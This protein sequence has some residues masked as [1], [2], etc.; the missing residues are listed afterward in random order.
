M[1]PNAWVSD[2]GTVPMTT[3]GATKTL[4]ALL[5]FVLLTTSQSLYGFQ[6]EAPSGGEGSGGTEGASMSAEQLNALLAPIALYPDPLVAQILAASTFPDQVAVADYWVQQNKSLTGSA[7]TQAVD[8]QTWDPSVKA[9]T[10]FP[11]VLD[12]MAK[13]LNWTSSLG[14]AYHDQPSEVMTAIQALRAQAKEKGNLKSNAQITVTQPSPQTIVIQP[15]NP[16]VVYVPEYDPAVIYGAPYVTPGYTAASVA[17]A[18]VI[19][20]GAGVAVG[21]LMSG[22]WGWGAWGCNWHG[23]AVVYNHNNFY[24]NTAWHGGYYNGGYHNGYGYHNAYNRSVNNN[25][26]RNNNFNRNGDDFKRNGIG[27]GGRASD[28]NSWAH[29]S[30]RS[31]AFSDV[32][33]HSGGWSARADSDRGWGSMRESGFSGG[34]FG[35]GGFHGGGFRR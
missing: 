10:A 26:D 5:S 4:A 33:E 27:S 31:D 9:L 18:G 1:T 16:Q 25:F 32:G 24:G 19:G 28:A 2:E 11:S 15:A 7:L 3:N 23:G 21:A 30:G 29:N 8:K 34:R 12:N 35:G 20:F 14:E 22:G 13:N 17:A 6:T